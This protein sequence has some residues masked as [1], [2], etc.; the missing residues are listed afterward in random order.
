M[1]YQIKESIIYTNEDGIEHKETY[2]LSIY[3][4]KEEAERVCKNLASSK[5]KHNSRVVYTYD[6]LEIKNGK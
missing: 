3:S 5:N 6:V 2:L 1:R 4:D